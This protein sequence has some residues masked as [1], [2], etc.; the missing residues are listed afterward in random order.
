MV[1][2]QAFVAVINITFGDAA[3]FF[4]ALRTS[5]SSNFQASR[6]APKWHLIRVEKQRAQVIII[7]IAIVSDVEAN[8]FLQIST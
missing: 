2:E 4:G 7:S 1:S 8:Y 6:R 3:D 5:N